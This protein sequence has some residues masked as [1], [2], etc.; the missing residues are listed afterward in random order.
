MT[1]ISL[2]YSL[3]N[4][5]FS[6]FRLSN[7]YIQYVG[8]L[9]VSTLGILTLV[10]PHEISYQTINTLNSPIIMSYSNLLE[11]KLILAMGINVG[12]INFQ[13]ALNFY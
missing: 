1:Y 9:E 11:P 5:Q 3:L 7:S 8:V 6:I 13:L 4:I 12:Y 2:E 10:T